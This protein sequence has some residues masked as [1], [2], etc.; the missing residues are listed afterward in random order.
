MFAPPES[1]ERTPVLPG[2]FRYPPGVSIFTKRNALVG[3]VTLKA[4]ERRR[5][6][7]KRHALR[8]AAFVVLGLVSAG[9][10]AALAAAVVRRQRGARVEP[11]RL[12][13]YAVADDLGDVAES[14]DAAE[15]D[16][17]LSEPEPGF[18]A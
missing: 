2:T 17:E 10:L 3:F 14:A 13:G 15:L 16:A 8:L 9:I 5:Q 18:A 11:Q 4:L 1:R 6:R 7:R 12:E